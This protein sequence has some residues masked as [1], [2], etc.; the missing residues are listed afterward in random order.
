MRDLKKPRHRLR[1]RR[2]SSAAHWS[3]RFP[4]IGRMR[5]GR[6]KNGASRSSFARSSRPGRCS[7][8][9]R[10]PAGRAHRRPSVGPGYRRARPTEILEHGLLLVNGPG[11][12]L[13]NQGD[14]RPTAPRAA[15]RYRAFLPH[16]HSLQ[17]TSRCHAGSCCSRRSTPAR[18][19][20]VIAAA[21]WHVWTRARDPTPTRPRRCADAEAPAPSAGNPAHTWAGAHRG[22]RSISA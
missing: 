14:V 8:I 12:F 19:L 9:A 1:S 7:A 22:R 18:T 16:G 6:H 20:T 5:A 13:R 17:R 2:L 11:P 21:R 4:A 15:I 3:W 10:T